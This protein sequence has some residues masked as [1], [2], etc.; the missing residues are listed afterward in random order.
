MAHYPDIAG[1][2]ETSSTK[3]ANLR[4]TY[5]QGAPP[6]LFMQD[7]SGMTLEEVSIAAWNRDQIEEYLS[8]KLS[9]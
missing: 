4:V 9:A 3:Y 1:F 5:T 6:A 7:K 2:V 8:E